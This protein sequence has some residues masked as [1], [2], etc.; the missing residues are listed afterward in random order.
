MALLDF[1]R[2]TKEKEKELK[3]QAN[4]IASVQPIASR[5]RQTRASA[6]SPLDFARSIS[7]VRGL[8]A[9][10]RSQPIAAAPR[11]TAQ[12]RV[13]PVSRT[14][15][16][17]FPVRFN[18]GP[19]GDITGVSGL[20]DN[21]IRQGRLPAAA[22][23]GVLAATRTALDV[24]PVR[25]VVQGF[26]Y[27]TQRVGGR[28]IG[29]Q[30][31]TPARPNVLSDVLL[32]GREGQRSGGA[33]GA[34]QQMA[35]SG[36]TTNLQK[37]GLAG[38][39]VV[40]LGTVLPAGDFVPGGAGKAG[41]LAGQTDNV[42]A[43]AARA[44]GKNLSPLEIIKQAP[45]PSEVLPR[46]AQTVAEG[47]VRSLPE[48]IRVSTAF[49]E[50]TRSLPE[51]RYNVISNVQTLEDGKKYLETFK[52]LDEA[53][54][55]FVTRP[56]DETLGR[57]EV[58][59]SKLI[60]DSLQQAGRYKELNGLFNNLAA[61][62]TATGQATQALA[63]FGRLTPTGAIRYAQNVIEDARR[64]LGK[65]P[66]GKGKNLTLTDEAS[67]QIA[68]QAKRAQD[69]LA[70]QGD[71]S[72]EFLN[73]SA[74]LANLINEQIPV[75]LAEKLR[76]YRNIS[77]LLNPK[78]SERN[79]I[80]GLV[81]SATDALTRIPSG[82]ADRAASL[83]TG[84]RTIGRRSATDVL[85][86]ARQGVGQ[87]INDVR[88]GIDTSRGAGGII[89]ATGRIPTFGKYD[90]TKGKIVGRDAKTVVGKLINGGLSRAEKA[91]GYS[92]KVPDRAIYEAVY[93]SE[94][95][96]LA[97]I[98]PKNIPEEALI[99]E[100]LY[101]AARSTFQDKN[102][103]STAL[104]GLRDAFNKIPGLKITTGKNKT[105]GLGDAIFAFTQVPGSI[106]QRGIELTPIIGA[107]PGAK[108]LHDIAKYTDNPEV[109]NWLLQRRASEIAGRQTVGT[110]IVGLGG[111]LGGLGI[112]TTKAPEDPDERALNEAKGI[113]PNSLNIDALGRFLASG[114]DPASAA[115]KEGDR[116]VNYDLFQPIAMPLTIGAEMAQNG[117]ES[118]FAGLTNASLAS[119]N[120][121]FE[122][123][124]FTG[125]ERIAKSIAYKEN[126]PAALLESLASIPSS[127]VPT[128]VSNMRYFVDPN[129]R[130]SFDE[131]MWQQAV[132]SVMN[133]IPG[134]SDKLAPRVNVFGEELTIQSD[135]PGKKF[136]SAFFNPFI[137]TKFNDDPAIK[138]VEN[139]ASEIG[140]NNFYPRRTTDTV[141]IPGVGSVDVTND[142]QAEMQKEYGEKIKA[143][144]D[145]LVTNETFLKKTPS[146]Q[147]KDI[148]SFE[149]ELYNDG[150][151]MRAYIKNLG[152][153][154]P[155]DASFWA[156]NDLLET[157]RGKSEE[158]KKYWLDLPDE[159]RARIIQERFT[160]GRYKKINTA[161]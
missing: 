69:V 8:R 64:I 4:P 12:G 102:G 123:P 50:V 18:Q 63:L 21:L 133:R 146:Q 49:D 54:T 35:Q 73:E 100:A 60:A 142:I 106:L 23:A 108:Q 128:F 159:E 101:Q 127:F 153:Q 51:Q 86:G 83:I 40:A 5:I 136:T 82:I 71:Q 113:R 33:F 92:L 45:S 84:Q 157:L 110:G 15:E 97:R 126:V 26:D 160:Q 105:F 140:D 74:I 22:N 151:K 52:G 150:V 143:Y 129:L 132:Y 94:L 147:A 61:R 130:Q 161:Q 134:L 41:R 116:M 37:G 76:S 47:E 72:Q 66:L 3:R 99:E 34:G 7:P 148:A 62:A 53:L 103:I 38:L 137:T 109:M 121:I 107:I 58:A 24:L 10:E 90:I 29:A 68:D 115:K 39:G 91:L 144:L 78:T 11:S 20:R 145:G 81:S 1:M 57:A 141:D 112:I 59:A 114:L 119:L 111:M 79:I 27:L 135:T 138:L 98:A 149:T 16:Q 85:A 122:Q 124:L 2:R 36:L 67:A 9:D 46:V 89:E 155:E 75:S 156:A 158:D 118:W 6:P 104:I 31:I 88:K 25:P 28:D 14:R 43:A 152:I 154:I 117:K 42:I 65:G 48:S 120:S 70:R 19:T 80:G 44:G 131:N 96:S 30:P 32:T 55:A 95:A 17:V 93:K 56:L 13:I 125:I 77:L 139:I 87:A